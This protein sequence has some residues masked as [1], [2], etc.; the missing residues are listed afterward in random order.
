MSSSED[1]DI[2]YGKPPKKNRF[3]K[4]IS[5]NPKG[6][7]RGSKNFKTILS[8]ELQRKVTITSGGKPKQVRKIEAITM[9]VTQ[10]ALEGDHKA[11]DTIIKATIDD[12]DQSAR[13]VLSPEESQRI[14]ERF[15]K[16]HK[17]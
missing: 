5:G 14:F 7:P 13:S 1:E 9:R 11:I 15:T 6:R 17:P 4:G 8:Q 10:K 3:P 2:G 16:R 12:T